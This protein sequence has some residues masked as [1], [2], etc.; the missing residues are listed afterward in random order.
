[1][2]HNFLEGTRS[3][4]SLARIVLSQSRKPANEVV[5]IQSL[6]VE[7]DINF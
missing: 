1:M 6:F 3:I 4:Q 2:L 5:S 7:K